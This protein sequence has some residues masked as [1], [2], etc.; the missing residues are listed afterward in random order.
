MEYQINDCLES[1]VMMYYRPRV[2]LKWLS[3]SHQDNR[4]TPLPESIPSSSHSY[5][6]LTGDG[7]KGTE[8]QAMEGEMEGETEGEMEGETELSHP[9]TMVPTYWS[10][11]GRNGYY[12]SSSS[13]LFGSIPTSW[14][15]QS[16]FI[17]GE[18]RDGFREFSAD[19]KLFPGI[20][21][22]VG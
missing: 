8:Q 19:V 18:K 12:R 15:S 3:R 1:R 16:Y 10:V 7:V 4:K 13:V 2:S 22:L 17:V 11:S 5:G 21:T 14:F 20:M 6:L 9:F